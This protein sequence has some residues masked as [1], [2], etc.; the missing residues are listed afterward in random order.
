M[1]TP[2]GVF[3]AAASC[4]ARPAV[5]SGEFGFTLAISVLL[6]SVTALRCARCW[7]RG[8]WGDHVAE[9]GAIAAGG[10][11]GAAGVYA[12]TLHACLAAPLVSATV[13]ALVALLAVML[14]PTLRQ[15]LTPREDRAMV[16]LTVN[17]P[18]GVALDYTDARM[19]EIEDILQPLRAAGEVTN[20]FSISGRGG[21]ANGGF[22]V[23]TLADWADR[24]RSQQEIVDE[25]NGKLRQVI[26]VRASAIQANSLR[27]RGGGQGLSFALLGDDYGQLATL[28]QDLVTRMRRKPRLGQV[29][30]GYDTTQ[31][32]L[33]VAVDRARA[34]DL[35]VRIA[36]LG[37]ALQSVLDGRWPPPSI[38][39]TTVSTC[40]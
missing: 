23:V 35:G 40:A 12:R 6:S 16:M 22:M 8:F 21:Q 34:E 27:I 13:A 36:G 9:G 39:A 33:F 28:S 19:R 37:E 30:L 10:R 14:F 11:Y 38:S 31:P 18:Q 1:T 15:E 20:L 29:R 5:C 25:L 26:G 2:A 17:A 32:Q 7:Q 4:P 3:G 24:T